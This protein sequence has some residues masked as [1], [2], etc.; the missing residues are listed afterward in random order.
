MNIFT[1]LATTLFAISTV[2]VSFAQANFDQMKPFGFVTVNS[3]TDKN[4][5]YNFTAGGT[6]EPDDK[7][8]GAVVITSNG[9]DMR[10]AILNAINNSS[11][12]VIILDGSKGDFV[13]SSYM[14]LNSKSN[15]TIVGINNAR[16]CTQWYVTDEIK[17][18]LDEQKVSS[19][20]KRCNGYCFSYIRAG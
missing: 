9:G 14:E 8:T 19:A 2:V 1:R 5:T 17:A 3:R 12:K 20:S 16:L 11:N 13:I 7:A 4:N 18:A 6:F 10:S 15:K